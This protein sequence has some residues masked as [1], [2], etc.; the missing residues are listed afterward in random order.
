MGQTK[1]PDW[2]E[3]FLAVAKTIAFKSKD[4][5][6]QVGAVVVSPD[7]LIVS[8]GFNGLA[9]GVYDDEDLLKDIDEK[10]KWI[11][12][13]EFNAI[14]NAARVGVALK[15]CEIFVTKFPCLN[16]CNAIVQVG[17]QRVYTHDNS[18]WSD[19]PADKEHTRKKPLLK[20][21]GVTVDAPFHP[22]FRPTPFA[23]LTPFQPYTLK[24][25][26]TSVHSRT[27]APAV[28]DDHMA[29]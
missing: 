26:D 13:A 22:D 21:G 11:C 3:Y 24:A 1:V 23:L 19:D 14:V 15:G 20:Q 4:T 9:R 8:T 28:S 18:Y 29:T 17:I 12:H 6:C 16:C 5:K 7:R 2:D 25:E 10:L 27:I